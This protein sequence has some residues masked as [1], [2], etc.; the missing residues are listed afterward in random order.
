MEVGV[1]E[2]EEDVKNSKGRNQTEENDCYRT[3]SN[4]LDQVRLR[5]IQNRDYNKIHARHH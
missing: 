4:N 3:T 1:E 5:T 2:I